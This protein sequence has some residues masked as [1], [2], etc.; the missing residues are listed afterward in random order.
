MKQLYVILTTLVFWIPTFAQRDKSPELL[1]S[2][3]NIIDVEEGVV[4]T[5]NECIYQRRSYS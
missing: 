3:V 1:I 5:G 2:N 4:K